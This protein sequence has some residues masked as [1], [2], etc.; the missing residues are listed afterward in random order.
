M[1]V[2]WQ[3]IEDKMPVGDCQNRSKSCNLAISTIYVPIW[4]VAK[5]RWK[6]IKGYATCIAQQEQGNHTSPLQRSWQRG[7]S[8]IWFLKRFHALD[9]I[10]S[11]IA[12]CW[13]SLSISTYSNM[14]PCLVK[15]MV[16]MVHRSSLYPKFR[17]LGEGLLDF[18]NP[19]PCTITSL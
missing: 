14:I 13:Y 18:T 15:R 17:H 5:K 10:S 7:S 2:C 16:N 3:N 1:C 12:S 9:P 8:E 4:M 19:C 11:N 6:I